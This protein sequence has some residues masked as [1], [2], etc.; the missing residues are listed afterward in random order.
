MAE[1]SERPTVVHFTASQMAAMETLLNFFITQRVPSAVFQTMELGKICR[2]DDPD[3]G[4]LSS[5]LKTRIIIFRGERNDWVVSIKLVAD[6]PYGNLPLHSTWHAAVVQ[7]ETEDG[8]TVW[9]R[10]TPGG[11]WERRT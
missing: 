3:C 7:I 10:N 1:Y 5:G 11:E 2:I 4:D 8:K 9:R 6:A